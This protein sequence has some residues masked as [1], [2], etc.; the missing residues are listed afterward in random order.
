VTPTPVIPVPG[1]RRETRTPP[2]GLTP[3]DPHPPTVRVPVITPPPPPESQLS[4]SVFSTPADPGD[5]PRMPCPGERYLGFRLVEEL[6][7]GSF[8]RVFLAEQEFLAGRKVALKVTLRPTREAERLAKLQHTNIVPV[9]SVHDAPPAQVICMPF[10]GRVTI[11]DLLRAFRRDHP[12]GLGSGRRTTRARAATS[13]ALTGSSQS[14]ASTGSSGSGGRPVPV[15][16]V[17]CD[18]VPL[19]GDVRA[20]LRVLIRLADGLAHAHDRGILHLDLKPANVLL[21]DTGEPMLLD[22]NLSF[23]TATPGRD[24]IGGTVPYMA[25]E[26][27]LDL[28]TRGQGAVDARTDLYSLGVMAF[29]MLTGS[30]PFPPAGRSPAD[31]PRLIEVRR[32]GPPSLRERN[33]AV[34]PA[35]ESIVRKLL[36]P[37]PADR[38]QSAADLRADLEAQLADRPLAF[39]PDR[40]PAERFGK[41]RRRNP[42][43]LARLVAAILIGLGLGVGGVAYSQSAVRAQAE[44][45]TRA[46]A[47][48]AALDPIRVDLATPGDATIRAR[49]VRR[50]EEVLREFGLPGD[51]DWQG[52]DAFLRL[53][54]GDRAALSADLGELLLLLAHARWQDGKHLAERERKAAADAALKLNRLARG[55]FPAEVVPPFL[56][57]QEAELAEAA[58]LPTPTGEPGEPAA[59]R[60]HFLDAVALLAA[61]KYATAIDPLEQVVAD[62]PNHAAAQFYLAFCRHQ[63][64]QYHRALERYDVARVLMPGDPRPRVNR[65]IVFVQQ[66]WFDQAEGEFTRAIKLDPSHGNAHYYRGIARYC[67]RKFREAEQDF[68]EALAWDAVPA[69]VYTYRAQARDQLGNKSAAAED[70]L[71]ARAHPPRREADFLARGLALVETDPDAALADFQKAA[72]LNPRS[73]PAL[74][75]QAHVLAEKLGDLDGALDAMTRAVELFPEVAAARAGR[76]VV[77]ARLGRREEAH[78]EGDLACRL[79]NDPGM[80]YKLACVY[81]LTSKDHPADADRAIR[82]LGQAFTAGFRDLRSIEKDKDL[83]PVRK[84]PKFAAVVKA[85]EELSRLR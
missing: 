12:S 40:S 53:P 28:R 13:T 17:T 24:L 46:R 42:G 68:T 30:A 9:Y 18:P 65:G 75:N 3:V 27:L 7:R 64:Q 33:P 57:R 23:D 39:A 47:T 63:L 73:L 35:V 20:V 22:F 78:E 82:L 38:Y 80:T 34:T 54:E 1:L 81:A 45:L 76:A 71:A 83:D 48:Q 77:L 2:A 32:Q 11:G 5:G 79:S 50:A 72:E 85:I 51:P 67:L 56:V 14:P 36:A 49:G 58:G 31:F 4:R 44:A 16:D 41:W 84:L 6:G 59:T 25:P 55:C 61:G 19:I 60:D 37:D 70:R 66:S 74:Q 8:A 43:T 15:I 69:Q 52:R 29:E 62:R 26:Q 21:A 10:L